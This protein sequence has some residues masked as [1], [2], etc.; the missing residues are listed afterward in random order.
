LHRQSE[1]IVI[2]LLEEGTHN[3]LKQYGK[4]SNF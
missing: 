3:K 4:N 1:R 2:M